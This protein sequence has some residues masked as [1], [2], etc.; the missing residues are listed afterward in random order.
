MN[1]PTF[2]DQPDQENSSV[3]FLLE[4]INGVSDPIFVKNRQHRW[5][6]LNH[7]FCEFI[8]ASRDELI[9]KSDYDLFPKAEADIF[10]EKDELVFITGMMNE[11]EESFT[12]ALG[13]NH[14]IS[15]KKSLFK[16]E[17]N[18]LF[19]VGIIR[20]I[21]DKIT[22][23]Q[24]I[25]KELQ[26][27]KQLLQLVM[28]NIPQ[29]ILWKDRNSVYLGCNHNA[30]RVAGLTPTDIVGKTDYDLSWSEQ[31]DF[32]RE[33]DRRIMDSGEAELHIIEPQQREDGIA[34][35][36]TNRIPLKD[37]E[38]NVI[39]IL[40]TIKDITER[41][42]AQERLNFQ[43]A[44]NHILANCTNLE[45]AIPGIIQAICENLDWDLGEFWTANPQSNLLDYSTNWY[46]PE[47]DITE[48]TD[49]TK[50]VTFG[51][52]V[53]LPGQI[54]L[55]NQFIWLNDLSRSQHFLRKEVAA[56]I[57]LQTA[58]GFPIN[59]ANR[60]VGVIILFS[61]K[62]RQKDDSLMEMLGA[63][64]NQI[65][66]FLARKYME[67]TLQNAYAEM[68][69]LILERT[70][71]LA[72]IN[73][74]LQQEINNRIE[75]EAKFQNLAANVPGML[76][77][78]VLHPDN[79]MSFPYV[80]SGCYELYGLSPEEIQADANTIFSLIHPSDRQNFQDTIITSAKTLQPW[81]WEGRLILNSGI[82]WIKGASRPQMQVNGAILWH[83]LL[84]DVTSRKQA[85]E[86]LQK[87]ESKYR[88]LVET[89]RDIIFSVDT[90]GY[91]TFVNQ[92]VKLIY[93]YEPEE[94]IGRHFTDFTP[95]EQIE[96]DLETFQRVLKEE[97]VF[98]YESIQ[99]AK[100]GT[101]LN[102]LFN[103]IVLQDAAGNILGTTGTATNITERKRAEKILQRT[104]A[105]LVA[106]QEAAIDGILIVDENMKV[107]SYNHCFP[108][109]W[110]I[111]L[112]VMESND[113][114]QLL[115][116]AVAK[117]AKPQKFL[118]QVEYLY[119]HP[120]Q[121]SSDEVLL[122]DGRTLDRYSAP[123][124]SQKGEYYGRIW[125]FRD[126]TERKQAEAALKASQKRLAL[127]I[128]QIPVAVIEWDINFHVKQW[129]PA[130]EKVFGYTQ[131]EA[132]GCNFE[133]IVP[134]HTKEH[135]KHI[136]NFLLS[137]TGGIFS[138]NEN[139]TKAGKIIT[140]EWHNTPLITEEGELIGVASM[141]VDITE[142]KQAETQ[143][144]QQTQELIKT[145]DE[146]QR[147]QI[148]LVHSEKMS[149]LGQLVAGV[150]HE[151]NNP[152]NF[153]YGNLTHASQYTQDL[154]DLLQL[155]QQNYPQITPEIQELAEAIDV[156]FIK[157][158]LP[159]LLLSMKVGAD[160]IRE[161]VLSLRTFSRLDEAEMKA[162][163]IHAGIDSTLMILE[164][165]F[166]AQNS[167][168]AIE[169]IK[170]YGDLPLVECYAGQLNQVFM[171]ILV[172]AI[173]AIESVGNSDFKPQ[174]RISTRLFAEN[175]VIIRISDN[176][177]GITKQVKEKLFDPFFTTK[178]IGKGTGMGLSISYQIITDRHG[179]TLECISQPGNGAEF[180]ITIPLT[181]QYKIP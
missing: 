136:T 83:G 135:V 90:Q 61:Q 130:A 174:I 131:Q 160:R 120:E 100:D 1:N 78:F 124:K 109:I 71:E 45:E 50:N 153:I 9:G 133:F 127:L 139:I 10:W 65:G 85:E 140:C 76:Y 164:S 88:H 147:T 66:Q 12:D 154:L 150:A 69:T 68:E 5:V 115:P 161:I 107:I 157:S 43:N 166:K 49:A 114:N 168:S 141:V 47:L 149:S 79:S 19:L 110:Q 158:D 152:V 81:Y 15:T 4:M 57:G 129:N 60:T 163:D 111:P 64:A 148:Q 40:S 39:G 176:G 84:M 180:V 162:V 51:Y 173:D 170:E 86:A 44:V 97:S 36:D 59:N 116:Y 24:L 181:Q 105:L 146:L 102:L 58:F 112:S 98:E 54:K 3:G 53:G 132:I 37:S 80:S 104:N 22:K 17:N 177:L 119:Q 126:I 67:K 55:Q 117:T 46:S 137:Q 18:N 34:W 8:G 11:N 118:A 169:V 48:F 77:E 92:A 172:N 32:Y 73:E 21:T 128:E 159:Q 94:C 74:T 134:E 125:Y 123:V 13:V 62:V 144:Q 145:L 101:Y 6:L 16:D 178:P 171:N 25:Q 7:A 138:V 42:I 93:G 31:A 33:C 14:V 113:D 26:E 122:K 108:E 63:I 52:G 23:Q 156:D 20:D 89:S 165:R 75:T 87:S 99:I 167:H 27:S 95:P 38:G 103:T 29:L 175:Q 143:L 2:M 28:D 142:R 82:K 70:K 179:G 30:A 72:Q 96:K 35:L 155:Y 121:T 41:K 106:Q 151:I 56:K 91:F